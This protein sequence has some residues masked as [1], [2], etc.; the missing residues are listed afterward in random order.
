ME[1]FTSATTLLQFFG[2]LERTQMAGE[3]GEREGAANGHFEP[4]WPCM[5]AASN[6][7][8]Q[9]AAYLC[10]VA[11]SSFMLGGDQLQGRKTCNTTDTN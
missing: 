7:Q 3:G 8:S 10:L 5:I 9:W 11:S 1:Q 2:V 4:D 6:V